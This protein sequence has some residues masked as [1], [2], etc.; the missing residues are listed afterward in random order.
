MAIYDASSQAFKALLLSLWIS[1]KSSESKYFNLILKKKGREQAAWRLS[2]RTLGNQAVVC[3]RP[4]AR[5]PE[6]APG[7]RAMG[8]K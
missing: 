7:N 1:S 6:T 8:Q 2:P 5:R 4:K 3:S